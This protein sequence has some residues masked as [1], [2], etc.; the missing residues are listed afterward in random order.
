VTTNPV[1]LL[2]HPF[3]PGLFGADPCGVCGEGP[4]A[5]AHAAPALPVHPYRDGQVP[6]VKGSATSGAAALSMEPSL[7]T[8]QGQVLEL[9][10]A[11][12]D[13]LTDDQLERLTGWRH[14]TVSARRRELVLAG[15]VRA[16]GQRRRTSSGRMAAVWVAP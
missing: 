4:E 15:L 7:A 13:G 14:Q 3:Q 12:A 2:P 10:R 9:I 16:N 8:K 5:T 1:P 11:R 6:S